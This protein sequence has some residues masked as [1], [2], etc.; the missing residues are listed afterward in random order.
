M[1]NAAILLTIF[2]AACQANSTAV[3]AAPKSASASSSAQSTIPIPTPQASTRVKAAGLYRHRY[4]NFTY[5]AESGPFKRTTIAQFDV[6]GMDIAANYLANTAAGKIAA[7]VYVYPVTAAVP[8]ID[9]RDADDE[10]L[11]RDIFEDAKAAA[12]KAYSNPWVR[13][14]GSFHSRF[15][16]NSGFRLLF[17]ADRRVNFPGIEEVFSAADGPLS[18][19]LYLFCGVGSEVKIN[20]VDTA[21]AIDNYWH[22]KYRF[23]YRQGADVGQMI[24]EFMSQVPGT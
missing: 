21:I 2:L 1:R 7:T 10:K 15:T 9:P 17:D 18:S 24:D 8:G 23:T 5:Q 20:T 12:L 22:V 3:D 14:T 16:P 6:D 11:C 19:E 13:E 4:V